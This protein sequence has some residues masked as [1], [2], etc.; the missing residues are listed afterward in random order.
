MQSSAIK[1]RGIDDVIAYIDSCPGIRGRA[2]VIWWL[3]LG[4]LFLDAFSNSALSAGL[5]PMTRD[6][7]LAPASVALLTSFAS[8]VA[9]A[10]NPIGGWMA[11]RWG[12]VRPLIL[13]KIL[14]V[15]GALLVVFAPGFEVILAGRFFVGAAYG[16][17]FAIAMAV[18]AEFTPVKLKSRLNT[19]QGMWYTAVCANLLLALLFYSWDV[20][21]AIWRYSVAAT[22]VF[23][24]AILL[25]QA[26]FL[27]E[28]PTWLAR[29][30][31]LDD[32]ASAMTRIYGRAF[33]AAPPAERIRVLNQ[34][35]RGLANVLL[36]FRGTYL[37]RTVLAA[38]VQI[39][40][41]IQYFAIGWYLPLISAALFGKD[42]VY[43]T[44]GALVF[45]VCGIVGGFL[46]P[47]VGRTLGLRRASA[48]G[49][50]AVFAMLLI[51]GLFNG[52]MP[53]W[54]AVVVPSLFILFHSAGP[55][56]NGKSLSS[57]SFRSELRAGANGIIGALGAI[58]AALGL[59][60][61]PLFRAQ[62]GL[63]TTFLILSVVPLLASVVCFSIRWDPTRTTIHPDNEADAPQFK[64]D[65]ADASALMHPVIE[66][67]RP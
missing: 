43:A 4:G 56:A 31:R 22:A 8:W 11:D 49:F 64:G 45:N 30:E 6:L 37:P 65:I 13:A 15:A 46:S 9:I 54:V 10:F 34:A 59:L 5:G 52:K 51:L 60:V 39:G 7:Q 16:I 29:K 2:G 44:I 50:A 57:L 21:D 58:G 14:A 27:V 42:F 67:A 28:S 40:Q 33:V 32:A 35:R 66:K 18:L 63:E 38:T 55:G 61:F 23:G 12:R 53:I 19:W 20:G 62:Y 26:L 47:L 36:I 41:S 3:A 24:V 1:L 48:F 17:D 25:L